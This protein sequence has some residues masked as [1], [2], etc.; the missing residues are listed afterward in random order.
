MALLSGAIGDYLLSSL[1]VLSFSC[2]SSPLADVLPCSLQVQS[3]ESKLDSL[4]DIYRQV[5]R[6]GSSSALTLSSLPLFELEQTSD[7]HSPVFSKDLSYST[8]V[9][10]SGAPPP[11]GCV[12]HS[13]TNSHLTQ[14]GLH[15]ILAPPNELNLNLSS[16]TPPSGLASSSFSPSPLPHQHHHHHHH[17]HHPHHSHHHHPQD[18]ATTPESGTDEAIGS[19]PPI[20]TPNSISSGGVGDGVFPLLPRLPPPLPPSQSG[21]PSNLV[22]A[23][24]TETTPN[25]EGFC[26]GL[27][28]QMEHSSVRENLGLG[29][30]LGR[31]AQQ[32]KRSTNSN[33]RLNTKEEGSWRRHMSLELE[34]LVPPAL[35]CC[36]GPCQM[37]RGLGKSMSVQDLI[38]AP[39]VAVQDSHHSHSLSS[40]SPS[41]S[42]DSP[43]GFHS[44]SQDPG[45]GGGGGG[46]VG[47]SGGAG[48]GEE[49]LFISDRDIETQGFDFLSQGTAE[50]HS[51]SSE[52]LRTDVRVG[53]G[54][55]G[56]H[57]SL[58][59]GQASSPSAGNTEMPNMP[60]VR[61]K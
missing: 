14:G 38:Q 28:T 8:Q 42:N 2:I 6:K 16:P 18:Q 9:S 22:R 12:T 34:P 39:P 61:L 1:I 7:Y 33:G 56:S 47:R 24:F 41:T 19:S 5:L 31:L 54:S 36:S 45:G 43:I 40:P 51:Y 26:R 52:L 17:H 23:T 3:I 37:D 59:S 48:W 32:L 4:L 20:L 58:A 49:D 60:C 53:A 15:L 55:P 25:M 44:C 27:G 46:G 50:A 30:G 29:F 21:G 10:S 11:G 35:G 13:A 57:H